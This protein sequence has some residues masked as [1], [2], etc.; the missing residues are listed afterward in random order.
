MTSTFLWLKEE[1]QMLT[2][3]PTLGK[4]A[5]P[6]PDYFPDIGTR[7]SL[8]PTIFQAL[9]TICHSREFVSILTRRSL[10]GEDGSRLG[11]SL[12]LALPIF[13]SCLLALFVAIFSPSLMKGFFS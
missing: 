10:P 8:D 12:G 5:V 13:F 2:P 3:F 1:S 6:A 4:Q 7:L 11:Y 9:E